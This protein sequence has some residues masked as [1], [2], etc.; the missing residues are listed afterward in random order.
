MKAKQPNLNLEI[1]FALFKWFAIILLLNNLVWAF[2]HFGYVSKSFGGIDS[3]INVSQDYN[4]S[5]NN[6]VAVNGKT[7][8]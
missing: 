5:N 3:S 2:L 6:T 1:F 4:E 8:S 7:N